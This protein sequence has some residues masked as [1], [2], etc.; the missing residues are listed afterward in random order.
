MSASPSPE[1][2][3]EAADGSDP[4][5]RPAIASAS[6]AGSWLRLIP[7]A[8]PAPPGGPAQTSGTDP[9]GPL[10]DTERETVERPSIGRTPG[11]RGDDPWAEAGRKVLR[12]H[13]ARTLVHVPGVIAG[14]DPDAVH[15]LRVGA[16]RMRAAWRV[17]GDG[18][19]PEAVRRH[20]ASLRAIGARLGAVRDLDVL[21][22]ILADH[23][24]H[25][26]ERAR[27]S[28][29]PL[30]RAWRADREIR[31]L[32]LVETLGSAAFARFIGEQ[33]AIAETVGLAAGPASST[34]PDLVRT[35]LP[36]SAWSAYGAVWAFDDHVAAAD[37]ATL[38]RLRIAAKWLRYTLEFA[39]EAFEPEATPLIRSVVALQDHLGEQH[40]RHVAATLAREFATASG[41]VLS[42]HELRSIERFTGALD[43]GVEQAGRAMVPAWRSL[44]A[45]AYRRRLGRGLARL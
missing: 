3:P 45:P 7:T 10:P 2:R 37:L 27:A 33:Q 31:R 24:L 1:R 35:R 42:R 6:P 29:A 30:A 32:E 15:D 44:V 41:S 17:F 23:G 8:P 14:D 19:E 40:D 22:G 9:D 28:L 36:A 39:R 11:L 25:G 26:S 5:D 43:E 34:S 18:F 13:L 20:R 4:V 38:H 12:F 16:R 21:L